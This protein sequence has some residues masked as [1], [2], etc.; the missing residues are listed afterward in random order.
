LR[1]SAE[2]PL[3]DELEKIAEHC[4]GLPVIDPRPAEEILAYG[5]NGIPRG[6]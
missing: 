6:D 1:D 4:A 5:E 3:A 2:Q